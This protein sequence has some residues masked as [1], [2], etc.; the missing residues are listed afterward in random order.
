MKFSHGDLELIRTDPIAHVRRGPKKT[1]FFGTSAYRIWQL[2][3]RI[4]H[5]KNDDLDAAQKYL[6]SNFWNTFKKTKNSE[7]RLNDWQEQLEKYAKDF[8]KLKHHVVDVGKRITFPF[9]AKVAMGGEI[10]RVDLIPGGGHAVYLFSKKDDNWTNELR[11]PLLQDFY[12]R[13]FGAPSNEVSIG[14]YC[15]ETS[16][17]VSKTFGPQSIKEAKEE[18]N[19]IAKILEKEERNR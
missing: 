19:E 15:L 7:R 3:T 6:E 2:A 12:A 18:I 5:Q 1:T 10:P 9:T 8:K 17:H 14:V 13:S 11:M 16:N 4:Y